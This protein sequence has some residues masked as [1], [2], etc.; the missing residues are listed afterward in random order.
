M[1]ELNL[2]E[3]VRCP[4]FTKNEE[5]HKLHKHL[6]DCPVYAEYTAN[7]P[8]ES[9]DNADLLKCPKMIEI[10]KNP[11]SFDKLKDC[12]AFQKCPHFNQDN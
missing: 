5:H 7:H 2:S 12:K 11:E 10:L 4:F 8:H 3:L 6:K 1:S 9:F